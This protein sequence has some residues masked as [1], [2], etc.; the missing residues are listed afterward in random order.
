[1]LHG[2]GTR[3]TQHGGTDDGSSRRWIGIC[4]PAPQRL[5]KVLDMAKRPIQVKRTAQGVMRSEELQ[6]ARELQCTN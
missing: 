3:G 6:V 5:T 1:M 2:A 4:Y